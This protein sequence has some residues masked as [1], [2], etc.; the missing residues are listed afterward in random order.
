MASWLTYCVHSI[1]ISSPLPRPLHLPPVR[2]V[3]SRFSCL[4]SK[5]QR[6]CQS[7][8]SLLWRG[9]ALLSAHSLPGTVRRSGK[10]KSTLRSRSGCGGFKITLRGSHV[11]RRPPVQ[12]PVITLSF[13]PVCVAAPPVLLARLLPSCFPSFSHPVL[14]PVAW[15]SYNC[16]CLRSCWSG[17]LPSSRVSVRIPST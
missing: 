13:R 9:L 4:A 14:L 15:Y 11:S 8:L 2:I 7:F 1:H 6:C 3:E 17:V 16:P 10:R 12:P 5:L